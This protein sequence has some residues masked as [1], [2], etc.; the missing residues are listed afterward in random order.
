MLLRAIHQTE[1]EGEYENKHLSADEMGPRACACGIV[2]CVSFPFPSTL[3]PDVRSGLRI[4]LWLEHIR[5]LDLEAFP[6]GNT[7]A[8][9]DFGGWLVPYTDHSEAS[10]SSV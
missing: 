5:I 4:L 9:S 1:R 10:A 7:A 2:Q 6:M 8:N 3:L